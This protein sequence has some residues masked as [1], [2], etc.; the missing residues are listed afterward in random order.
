MNLEKSGLE[1]SLTEVLSS[2]SSAIT[3]LLC[4]LGGGCV[5]MCVLLFD[6]NSSYVDLAGLELGA[7]PLTSVS[8]VLR[9]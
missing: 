4:I 1:S 8:W 6:I 3:V 9:L 7:C 5:C 2:I